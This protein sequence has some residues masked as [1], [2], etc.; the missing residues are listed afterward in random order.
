MSMAPGTRLRCESCK[1][2]AIIV[3]ADDQ[4]ELSCCEAP[5]V[6]IF[7]PGAASGS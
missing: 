6:V 4:P 7:S 1:S 3:K 2:E 5:L